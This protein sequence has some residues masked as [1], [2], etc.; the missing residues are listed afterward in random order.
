LHLLARTDGDP[1][2]AVGASKRKQSK[3]R[4][5]TESDGKVAVFKGDALGFLPDG[6]YR[7]RRVVDRE[8]Y[9][10]RVVDRYASGFV[11]EATLLYEY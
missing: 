5:R 11:E 7:I 1:H 4:H 10:Q 8:A 6:Y 3:G 2:P 9:V